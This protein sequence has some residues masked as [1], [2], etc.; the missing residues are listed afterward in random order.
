MKKKFTGKHSNGEN[1]YD[2]AMVFLIELECNPE[3]KVCVQILRDQM[4]STKVSALNNNFPD[5]LEH[6]AIAMNRIR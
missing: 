3:N 5:V 2:V 4:S 6:I 1:F